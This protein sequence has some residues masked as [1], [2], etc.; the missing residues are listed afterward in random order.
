MPPVSR[1]ADIRFYQINPLGIDDLPS[2]LLDPGLMPSQYYDLVRRRSGLT[3]ERKLSLAV[4]EM[5]IRDLATYSPE[6]KLYAS[7]WS[8]LA[9]FDG[10][11]RE[12]FEALDLN[13]EAVSHLVRSNQRFR[14]WAKPPR[15]RAVLRSETLKI[16]RRIPGTGSTAKSPHCPLASIPLAS[17]PSE[18]MGQR[19]EDVASASAVVHAD[20][21]LRDA[22]APRAAPRV[23]RGRTKDRQRGLSSAEEW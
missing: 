7:A 13:F 16:L 9:G 4:V 6:S 14:P 17:P 15:N 10:N 12:T 19:I 18:D 20:R 3:P 22:N 21:R 11:A 8:W 1:T 2:A 5:A 23:A